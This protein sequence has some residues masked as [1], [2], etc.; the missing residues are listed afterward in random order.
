MFV[1]TSMFSAIFTKGHKFS[2]F[3][4]VSLDKFCGFPLVSLDKF[5]G[6]PLVSLDKFCGF[7]LVS[8]DKFCGFP[9]VSLDNVTSPERNLFIKERIYLLLMSKFFPFKN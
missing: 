7:P 8:L 1:Y 2:G 5:C 4:L 9:L 6:F 3:P